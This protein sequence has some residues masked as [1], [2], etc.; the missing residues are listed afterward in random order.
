M[1]G[2]FH[3]KTNL[4]QVKKSM[5]KSHKHHIVPRSRG[6][7]DSKENIVSLSPY[8]HALHHALDFLEG[9]PHF[10]FRHE[11]W[12]FL[13]EELKTK[14]KEEKSRRIKLNHPMDYPG[15]REKV[16]EK[17]SGVNN[18]MFGRVGELNP[19][20]GKPSAFRGK[21]HTP[22]ILKRISE[23]HKGKIVSEETKEK[24]RKASTGRTPSPEKG[25]AH[26]QKM[27]GRHW[28]TGPN[29]ETLFR[30]Q[31]PSSDWVPGR[32][33]KNHDNENRRSC[34]F[35]KKPSYQERSL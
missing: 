6:G 7:P 3:T 32:K 26:R 24:L 22:E 19:A 29:G 35:F 33:L 28:W 17:I 5:T 10:D 12:P 15:A 14:V 11:A 34:H 27:T 20:F 31:P 16:S 25:E 30:H 9:G 23:A 13:P 18:P 21:K 2:T 4:K 8:D 1:G